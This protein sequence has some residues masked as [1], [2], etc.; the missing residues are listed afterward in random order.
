MIKTILI[1]SNLIPF[2]LK[3]KTGDVLIVFDLD[4]TPEI[5]RIKLRV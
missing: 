4:E 2:T 3:S 5:H 1:F